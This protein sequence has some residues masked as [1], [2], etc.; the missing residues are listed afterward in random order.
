M[1]EARLSSLGLFSDRAIGIRSRLLVQESEKRL[2]R[3]AHQGRVWRSTYFERLDGRF[4]GARMVST[5]V[6]LFRRSASRTGMNWPVPASRPAFRVVINWLHKMESHIKLG[7]EALIFRIPLA[8]LTRAH[9][10]TCLPRRRSPETLRLDVFQVGII[11]TGDT[12]GISQLLDLTT[13]IRV[14]RRS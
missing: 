12:V 4:D 2:N 6:V 3:R 11:P 13:V 14:A 10:A 8:T 9:K 5:T 1:S 7:W